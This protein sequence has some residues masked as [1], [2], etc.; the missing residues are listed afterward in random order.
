MIIFKLNNHKWKITSW[1]R[2]WVFSFLIAGAYRDFIFRSEF[3]INSYCTKRTKAE[4]WTPTSSSLQKINYD[5]AWSTRQQSKNNAETLQIIQNNFLI[6]QLF[7]QHP[8]SSI[9]P[10]SKTWKSDWNHS[11]VIPQKINWSNY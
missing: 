6:Y 5:L 4:R 1:L 9:E 3:S 7:K 8:R 11:V 2:R 10:T